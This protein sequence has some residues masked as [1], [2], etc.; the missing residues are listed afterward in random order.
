[1]LCSFFR[2]V[3]AAICRRRL[4]SIAKRTLLLGASLR[5]RIYDLAAQLDVS[6]VKQSRQIPRYEIARG[7]AETDDSYVKVNRA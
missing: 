3:H 2:G 6:D 5:W 4:R 7:I 1:M